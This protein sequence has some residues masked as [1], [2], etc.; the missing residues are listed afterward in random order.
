ML[1]HSQLSAFLGGLKLETRWPVQPPPVG[2]NL[3][4]TLQSGYAWKYP[5]LARCVENAQNLPEYRVPQARVHSA[6]Y[7]PQTK[8][9]SK[10]P[11]AERISRSQGTIAAWTFTAI[12]DP[13]A[14]TNPWGSE[15]L[16]GFPDYR[17]QSAAA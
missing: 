11:R 13:M 10:A 5:S 3:V 4:Q 15:A 17:V 12:G 14:G 6:A 7:T 2:S 9:C 16:R 1:A 8:T